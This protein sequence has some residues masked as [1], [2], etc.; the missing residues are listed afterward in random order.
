MTDI[1]KQWKERVY[2]ALLE[3][4]AENGQDQAA[5][6]LEAIVAEFPPKPELGDIGFP[7]FG[8]AKLLRKSPA[9]IAVDMERRLGQNSAGALVGAGAAKAVGPYLNVFFDRNATGEEIL[10]RGKNAEWN[11]YRPLADR[12]I[13]V[14]FSCPQHEQTASSGAPEEQYSRRI[15]V[16]DPENRWRRCQESESHQ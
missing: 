11:S 7:M 12:K 5:I 2:G 1:K 9:A 15:A 8:Y 10:G 14:E 3:L 16:E 6:S 4:A 13:M